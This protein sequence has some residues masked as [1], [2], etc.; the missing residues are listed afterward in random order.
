LLD[1]LLLPWNIYARHDLFST[2]G[3]SIELPGLLFPLAIFAPFS[4]KGSAATAL[5]ALL[6]LRFGFWAI[7]AQQIRMLLPLFPGM[8]VL[9]A[10]G[11]GVLAGK[12][13]GKMIW[14]VLSA[15]VIGGLAFTTVFYQLLDT[16]AT[17]PWKPALGMESKAQFL[18]RM[19]TDYGATQ[20]VLQELPLQSRVFFLWDGRGYYCDTRCIPDTTHGQWTDFVVSNPLPAELSAL[21]RGRGITYLLVS[22]SDAVFLLQHDPQGEQNNAWNYLVNEFIPQC[23]NQIYRDSNS[24]VFEINCK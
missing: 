10:L 11:I 9:A 2:V 5:A 21:L 15:G 18:E 16:A 6:I 20:F 22:E 19:V 23:A 17:A 7:G 24:A 4:K 12:L 1:Y 8:A 14:R 3:G 13:G